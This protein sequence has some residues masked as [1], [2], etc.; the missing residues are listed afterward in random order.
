MDPPDLRYGF[1]MSQYNLKYSLKTVGL[2][3]A[4]QIQHRL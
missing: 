4:N 1:Q 3:D 2:W